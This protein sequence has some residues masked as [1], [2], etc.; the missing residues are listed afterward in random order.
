MILWWFI[1]WVIMMIV[2]MVH[3]L[4]LT[5]MIIL[6]S[7]MMVGVHFD[8]YAILHHGAFVHRCGATWPMAGVALPW[9]ST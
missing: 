5:L 9:N 3:G 8:D 4:C 2:V 7:M 1:I 6:L